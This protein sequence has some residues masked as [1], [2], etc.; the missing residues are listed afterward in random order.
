MIQSHQANI[1][2]LPMQ[3]TC[4]SSFC[5]YIVTQLL[6]PLPSYLPTALKSCRTRHFTLLGGQ[7]KD[8]AWEGDAGLSAKIARLPACYEDP[9]QSRTER[10]LLAMLEEPQ[11]LWKQFLV[12]CACLWPLCKDVHSAAIYGLQECSCAGQHCSCLTGL[13]TELSLTGKEQEPLH[14]LGQGN[15]N[16]TLICSAT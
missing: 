10:L 15:T 12:V 5:R 14:V 6:R 2:Q 7:R 11:A 1:H 8:T 9:W 16:G 13:G 4:Q 3:R